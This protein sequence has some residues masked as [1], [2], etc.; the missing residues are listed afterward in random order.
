MK[1]LIFYAGIVFV[2]AL[3]VLYFFDW[4]NT[5]S[6]SRSGNGN[7]LELTANVYDAIS[8][9]MII[10][11]E[12]ITHITTPERVMG[13][14]MTSWVGS[15]KSLRNKL[16]D[17]V[18]NST[19]NSIVLDIKDY[20]GVIAFDIDNELIDSYGTDSNRILDIKDFI[21]ELHDVGIYVIG[22]ITVFQDSLLAKKHP[23]FGVHRASDGGLW[24]DK[25][26]LS[27]LDPGSED[28][29]EYVSVIAE[30]S[31]NLGFDEINFD[32]IRYPSDGNI[33]DIKY[34][35]IESGKK[36]DV[37]RRFY[38]YLYDRLSVE[39][40]IPISADLFGMTTTNTDDLGIG[41]NLEDALIYFD[42]VAPMVYPS[43]YPKN[44]SG[45][46]NPA[47]NPYEIIKI[48]MKSGADRANAI[49]ISV[50]KLRPWIQ[51][52]DLGAN[53][54]LNMVQAQM[55][56]LYEVGLDSYMSWDPKNQYTKGA[57]YE[58]LFNSFYKEYIPPIVPVE[59]APKIDEPIESGELE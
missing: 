23:E 51:D 48:A 53:Y 39:K 22:R 30:E 50:D 12:V 20:S 52:F 11:E 32:Y 9:D 18:K 3:A 16:F 25:K 1:K 29:W 33:A 21:K 15:S 57:Y 24:K 27:Y 44:F 19:I 54:D 31:Y 13:V 49:G 36:V 41:Q 56:A 26:G 2:A 10:P 17:F 6:Y 42:F 45:Y 28:V 37:L 8:G 4:G 47:A 14:Y 59:E 35:L 46:S 38:K 5:I 34:D 7:D 58:D 55:K 40:G 43:H